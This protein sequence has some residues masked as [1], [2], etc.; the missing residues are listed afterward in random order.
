MPKTSID[1]HIMT[2]GHTQASAYWSR[3]KLLTHLAMLVSTL[4]LSSQSSATQLNLSPVQG[5]KSGDRDPYAL[6]PPTELPR[7]AGLKDT[8][9]AERIAKITANSLSATPM[10]Q[11]VLHTA[12]LLPGEGLYDISLKAA[13]DLAM[14]RD[15][16]LRGNVS[17]DHAAS[18]KAAEFIQAWADVYKPSFMPI[19]ETKFDALMIAYDLLPKDIKAGLKPN[20][21][22]LWVQFAVGYR[23]TKQGGMSAT[24]NINSHRVKLLTLSAFLVGD[25]DL[26]AIAHAEYEQQLLA[27]I[28]ADG[29]VIDFHERDAIHYVVYSLEPLVFAALAGHQHQQDWWSNQNK[30]LSKA[31]AWLFPYADG[32]HHHEEFA[33][34]PIGFDKKRQMAGIAGY[35]GLFNPRDAGYVMALAARFEP[36][37]YTA[38]AKASYKSPAWLDVLMPFMDPT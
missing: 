9:I 23:N 1:H 25:P 35:S 20:V 37:L 21:R 17:Q 26:I 3:R 33:H 36:Q 29:V 10:P 11:Q 4:T 22:D 30:R 16:A 13:N 27:N 2:T 6:F 12:G 31:V 19:D 34:S 28:S 24:S 7:L 14:A 38:I 5:R 18:V 15:L 8:K 32:S